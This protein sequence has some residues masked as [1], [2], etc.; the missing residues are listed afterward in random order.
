MTLPLFF[1][2]LLSL[3]LD[4]PPT[5]IT[6]D[7]HTVLFITGSKYNLQ[8]LYE[9]ELETVF[10]P[11]ILAAQE[12]HS[13]AMLDLDPSYT[14]GEGATARP[15]ALYTC[16]GGDE[17]CQALI[18]D[19]ELTR[20]GK[21][22]K[23]NNIGV[24]KFSAQRSKSQQPND[25]SQF[26]NSL[27]TYVKSRAYRTADI[28]AVEAALSGPQ[29]LALA[30]FDALKIQPAS[31]RTFRHFILLFSKM[32]SKLNTHGI[33]MDSYADSGMY[34]SPPPPPPLPQV[35]PNPST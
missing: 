33:V 28:E 24:M 30:K 7:A 35:N 12:S 31:K 25:V 10:L 6:F 26:F 8:E 11:T 16:D 14:P 29:R 1:F 2:S 3:P 19:G 23:D 13:A 20:F 34:S 5:R 4:S 21:M 15:H 17:H 32:H 22:F 18:K 9:K 27:K